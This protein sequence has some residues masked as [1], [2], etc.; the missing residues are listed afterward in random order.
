MYVPP[1][2]GTMTAVPHTAIQAETNVKFRVSYQ[3]AQ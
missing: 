3:A 1:G 2:G